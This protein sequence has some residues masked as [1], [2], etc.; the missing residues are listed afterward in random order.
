MKFKIILL[1]LLLTFFTACDN[2]SEFID[3]T[4]ECEFYDNI[5]ST[6]FYGSSNSDYDEVVFWD[7]NS[8][9]DFGGQVRIYP[10]NI[11]CD[12]AQLPLIDFF[13]YTLLSIKT[14]GSGCSATYVRKILIN[15]KNKELIYEISVNYTGACEM[16]VGSRNWA[17]IPKISD[18]YT[19]DFI[20][21]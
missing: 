18:N 7:N 17:I 20:L 1:G 16:I 10:V 6:C 8:F 13:N 2:D 3:I 5:L 9:Q 14:S 19:V 12:T 15:Q 11:N 21:K 4:D